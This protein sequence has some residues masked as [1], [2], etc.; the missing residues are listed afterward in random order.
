[1]IPLQWNSITKTAQP[2]A[3]LPMK[4]MPVMNSLLVPWSTTVFNL[5]QST[6]LAQD[7]KLTQKPLLLVL[8]ENG[9]N[10]M[11]KTPFG[12][13]IHAN[14]STNWK[15]S[16]MKNSAPKLL[17][18]MDQLKLHAS[19]INTVMTSSWTKVPN[20]SSKPGNYQTF[21]KVSQLTFTIPTLVQPI[22][23]PGIFLRPPRSTS[24]LLTAH[25]WADGLTL[26]LFSGLDQSMFLLRQKLL[27]SRE[28]TRR[29]WTGTSQKISA[30]ITTIKNSALSQ[31][32][33]TESDTTQLQLISW[34]EL[35]SYKDEN[36]M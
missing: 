15:W 30:R 23:K 31:S 1:M 33:K 35:F 11:V 17:D 14:T 26:D 34:K 18:Q 27:R 24:F 19:A 6:T 9:G 2:S 8:M 20:T 12:I 10:N 25:T 22:M 16:T 36:L 4:T 28:S 29:R 13:A 21:K 5:P 32:P 7:Q 3:P